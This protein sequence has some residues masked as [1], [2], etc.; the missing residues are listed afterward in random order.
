M[1]SRFHFTVFTVHAVVKYAKK[2]RSKS[3]SNLSVVQ[4]PPSLSKIIADHPCSAIAL[5][6]LSGVSFLAGRLSA[7]VAR[8]GS[9]RPIRYLLAQ[10]RLRPLPLRK[11][12]FTITAAR[13]SIDNSAKLT[14]KSGLSGYQGYQRRPIWTEQDMAEVV[15]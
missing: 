1:V 2:G 14:I 5:T 11:D 6:S 7:S 13:L 3:K 9:P 12:F 4:T 8:S 15:S 10:P